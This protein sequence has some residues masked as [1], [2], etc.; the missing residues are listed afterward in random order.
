MERLTVSFTVCSANMMHAQTFIKYN[1]ILFI[2]RPELLGLQFKYSF[3]TV[4]GL[5]ISLLQ[6]VFDS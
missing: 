6:Y 1:I 3:W 4:N 5:F 2:G